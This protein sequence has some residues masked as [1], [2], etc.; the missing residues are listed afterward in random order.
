MGCL[1]AI[2]G[3]LLPRVLMVFIVLLTN[4]FSLAFQTTLWPLLG[5]VFA[6]YTTLVYM[7]A[8]I[9]NG[10]VTGWWLALVVFAVLVD[11]GVV[12]GSGRKARA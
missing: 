8:M 7:A 10:E 12:G 9:N 11:I 6:P 1:L 4:W 2:I 5:W 3:L